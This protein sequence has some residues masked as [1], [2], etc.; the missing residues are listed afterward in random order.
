MNVLKN[1]FK[2]IIDTSDSLAELKTRCF[3]FYSAHAKIKR[4]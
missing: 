1:D 3:D 2:S 4:V